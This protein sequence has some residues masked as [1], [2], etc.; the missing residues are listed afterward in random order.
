[1]SE[2]LLKAALVQKNAVTEAELALINRQTLRP[3]EDSEVFSFRLAACD[4]QIDRD[5][6]RFTDAA[7]E[8]MAPLFV[9]RP[10]LMDHK[11]SAGS[12][13]A[14]VYA[15]EVEQA[16]AVRR[17]VLRCYMPRTD[18]TGPT[19]TA[20]ESGILRESSVGLAMG[21][22]VCSICGANQ[23][24]AMCRHFPGRDYD[25]KTCHMELDEPKD[26][27]EVSLV[28]VP[29]QPGA[30]IIKSKRYGGEGEPQ[31]GADAPETEALRLAE[32][33]MELEQK[34]YGGKGA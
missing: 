31:T 22:A 7:L 27:Y 20:I 18:Q 4:N 21:K 24:E 9:G 28:A 8:A 12:Q 10:V 25:G 26:A 14:R 33:R 1:M 30:G 32:A 17:L 15:A 5:H 13:T 16:G 19:V 11:W 34:R 29:A 23:R 3:L 6:E 2:I